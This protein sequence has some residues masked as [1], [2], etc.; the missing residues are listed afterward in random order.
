MGPTNVAL[1]KYFQADHELREAKERLDAASKDVRVQE[2]R[3]NDAAE[4]HRQ[5]Q[6]RLKESQAKAGALDVDLKSRDAHIEKL[7]TQQQNAKNN[8]EYQTFLIEINTQKVD[9]NKV[10][11][12]AMKLL[13]SVERGNKE[14]VELATQLEGERT[15]LAAMK[16]QIGGR[17]ATL[18]A[19][20]DAIKPKV[21]EA[22]KSVPPKAREAFDRLNDRL[23][24]EAMSAIAKPDRRREEYVCTAC[25]MD[26][27]VDVY[28]KLHSRD[29][30]V[31]CPSCRRI[32][33]IPDDL[34][35]EVAIKGKPAA[36][37]SDEVSSTP[38]AK[39]PK[40]PRATRIRK[41]G[42][43]AVDELTRVLMKAQGESV[44]NAVTAGNDPI[45]FEVSLDGKR[46]GTF[47]GQNADNFARTARFCLQEA[48]I[49]GT[50]V[51]TEKG[52]KVSQETAASETAAEPVVPPPAVPAPDVPPAAAP[53][54]EPASEAPPESSET[55]TDESAAHEQHGITT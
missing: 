18:Q 51:L 16:E 25:N 9:R 33:Y 11:E 12:E 41:T 35:P 2:R 40:A 10:E 39:A 8:K 20:I 38:G 19:E 45:E 4:K 34:P 47:K 54:P 26:L 22:G 14:L 30:L 13:E 23:D 31:F 1:V 37:K 43:A 36:R 52:S 44:R 15:K 50:L 7:R 32:L 5:S 17:L 55:S 42:N 27:V 48:G 3:V 21:D 46:V 53:A 29:E 6:Q 24:G 49:P 28:N